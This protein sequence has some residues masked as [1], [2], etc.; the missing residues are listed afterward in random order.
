M[1]GDAP[2]FWRMAWA[3][4]WATN[5]SGAAGRCFWFVAK[6]FVFIF[7]YIWVRGTMP[8]FRYDQLMHLDEV[9]AAAGDCEFGDHGF[10][11]ALKA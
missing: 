5:S 3:G 7:I 11:C 8:R 9:F 2:V 1:P 6:V 10:D 4:V